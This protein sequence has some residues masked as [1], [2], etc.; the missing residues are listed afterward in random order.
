[1]ETIAAKDFIQIFNALPDDK[2]KEV[3]DFTE[4]LRSR[5]VVGKVRKES[6]IE[7]IYGSAKGSKLTSDLFSRMKLDEKALEDK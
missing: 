2:K 6:L 5:T 3:Y 7:R 4:F 1:M